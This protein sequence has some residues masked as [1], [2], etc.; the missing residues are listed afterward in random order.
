MDKIVF[1]TTPITLDYNTFTADFNYLTMQ[2]QNVMMR[3]SYVISL[4]YYINN[5]LPYV[6]NIDKLD[7]GFK[8]LELLW[9]DDCQLKN[10]CQVNWMPVRSSGNLFPRFVIVGLNPGI[11]EYLNTS[12]W[13]SFFS[14]SGPS[15]VTLRKALDKLGILKD[16]WLTNLCR[17]STPNNAKPRMHEA[18][19]CYRLWLEAE[20]FTLMPEKIFVL[21]NDCAELA[22]KIGIKFTK[23]KHPSYFVRKGLQEE[24]YKEFEK[25][26]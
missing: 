16:A 13:G 15:T 24:Y 17:C 5:Y 19:S 1:S 12:D 6:D 9:K 8:K 10:S 21:G 11:G 26:I 7:E 3:N 25:Y 14:G 18:L 23:I 20:L 2:K 4:S 22:E